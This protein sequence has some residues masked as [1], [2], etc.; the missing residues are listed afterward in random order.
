VTTHVAQR[1]ARGAVVFDLDDTL[2]PERQFALGGFRAAAHAA[3]ERFDRDPR[4]LLRRLVSEFRRGARS[5]VFQ[6]VCE[7]EALPPDSV[8]LM[9][10]AYRLHVPRL[11]LPSESCAVIAACRA[12]A[13]VAVLTNGD[14]SVQRGKI[15]ALGV[16]A[17]VDVV[18]Y[19][20]EHHPLG[21]PAHAP[22]LAVERALGVDPARCVMVGDTLEKDVAGA[23]GA[24]W[25][26]IWKRPRRAAS[27]GS[28]PE[29]VI[30]V[31]RL[32]EVPLLAEKILQE[33]HVGYGHAHRTS[34]DRQG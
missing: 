4:C 32:A 8:A 5:T 17:L 26:P 3:A 7:A 15:A 31:T 25:R 12:S 14:P 11:V 34:A 6:L 1:S 29:S 16:E 10:T 24:G 2:Y 20:A 18:V 33:G 13:H 21:K 19:A 30:V 23:L 22:F 27:C 9:L 28:V